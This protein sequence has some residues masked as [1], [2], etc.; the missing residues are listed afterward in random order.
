MCSVIYC[1]SIEETHSLMELWGGNIVCSK[2]PKISC[3]DFTAFFR[4]AKSHNVYEIIYFSLGETANGDSVNAV[5]HKGKE[6]P[7]LNYHCHQT[8]DLVCQR[9]VVTKMT[10][11][12]PGPAV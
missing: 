2:G 11:A 12:A 5:S 9:V 3:S 1:S 6:I 7:A 4:A 10:I 8:W